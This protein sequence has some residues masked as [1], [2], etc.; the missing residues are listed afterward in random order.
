MK[1]NQEHILWKNL[2]DIE[3]FFHKAIQKELLKI[4]KL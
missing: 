3:I 4:N 1:Y 2:K